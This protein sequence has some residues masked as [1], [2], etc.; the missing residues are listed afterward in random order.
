MD[1][2]CFSTRRNSS[3]V[4]AD[5]PVHIT[6]GTGS[7]DTAATETHGRGVGLNTCPAPVDLASGPKISPSWNA[8]SKNTPGETKLFL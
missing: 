3:D 5:E 4:S 8:A 2:F 6:V 7:I 1:I